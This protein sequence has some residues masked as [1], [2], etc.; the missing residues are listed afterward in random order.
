MSLDNVLE[1][2][3]LKIHF[4]K[5]KTAQLKRGQCIHCNWKTKLLIVFCGSRIRLSKALTRVHFSSSSMVSLSQKPNLHHM[6]KMLFKLWVS[7]TM[8][9]LGTASE[10]GVLQQQHRLEWR[11]QLFALWIGGT[12]QPSSCT[13]IHLLQN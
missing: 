7:P 11:I 12:V 4:K 9:W 13:T 8:I 2:T 1:P 3:T 10:S 6:Y 5:S